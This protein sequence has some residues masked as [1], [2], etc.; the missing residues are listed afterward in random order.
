[1]AKK[2]QPFRME[3]EQAFRVADLPAV[4][5]A[6]RAKVKALGFLLATYT[7]GDGTLPDAARRARITTEF[8]PEQ[9]GDH[10]LTPFGVGR[11]CSMVRSAKP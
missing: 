8:T 4:P 2:E 10:E 5:K 1:M 11:A 9:T 7:N 6:A 3:W